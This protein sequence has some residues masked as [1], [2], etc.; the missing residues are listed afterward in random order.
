MTELLNPA[1]RSSLAVRLR[2]FEM[3]LRQADAWLQRDPG[4]GLLYRYTVDLT[5][6]QRAAIRAEIQVAL[7]EIARLVEKF[8]LVPHRQHFS[9]MLAAQMSGEW[10]SLC[11]VRAEKLRRYGDVDPRLPMQLNPGI[12]TLI[13]LAATLARLAADPA[14]R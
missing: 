12:D 2:T 6:Q 8:E 7:A 1:Q 4:D 14:L 3:T 10:S 13:E 11:D 5:P 9:S